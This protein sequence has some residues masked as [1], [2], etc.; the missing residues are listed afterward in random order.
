MCT[1]V[2]IQGHVTNAQRNISCKWITF[3][4]LQTSDRQ[5]LSAC[6]MVLQCHS[7][8]LSRIWGS[9]ST[10][11]IEQSFPVSIPSATNLF[12]QITGTVPIPL[13][14]W[15]SWCWA[16]FHHMVMV[17]SL[18]YS[19]WLVIKVNPGYVHGDGHTT[20][21]SKH[22]QSQPTALDLQ[23]NLLKN[24]CTNQWRVQSRT[25]IF[26]TSTQTDW[27]CNITQKL[28]YLWKQILSA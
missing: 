19:C 17:S 18:T 10:N 8:L 11:V 6:L 28:G 22:S 24:P 23:I 7:I 3:S 27:L 16:H 26:N 5:L 14:L 4:R 12:I 21:P 15:I 2:D 9:N 25:E 20:H 13:P 1:W